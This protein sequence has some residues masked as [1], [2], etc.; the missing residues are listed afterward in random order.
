MNDEKPNMMSN[1]SYF[2]IPGAIS[3]FLLA[4]SPGE[5]TRYA[6]ILLIIPVLSTIVIYFIATNYDRTKENGENIAKAGQFFYFSLLIHS[7]G[8]VIIHFLYIYSTNNLN[9]QESTLEFAHIFKWIPFIFT[10]ISIGRVIKLTMNL[11]DRDS[12]N[13][14]KTNQFVYAH[15]FGAVLTFFSIFLFIAYYL[16][17]AIGFDDSFGY[18]KNRGVIS[19]CSFSQ[20]AKTDKQENPFSLSI[21]TSV[22]ASSSDIN[23]EDK[24][25]IFAILFGV[26]NTTLRKIDIDKEIS[27]SCEVWVGQKW[28]ENVISTIGDEYN[29]TQLCNFLVFFENLK[30]NPEL[31]FQIKLLSIPTGGNGQENEKIGKDR[32]TD[33][34]EKIRKI[35]KSLGIKDDDIIIETKEKQQPDYADESELPDKAKLP[36]VLI[37]VSISKKPFLIA[38]E[39]FREKLK[40]DITKE[41]TNFI[42]IS[43][44]LNKNLENCANQSVSDKCNSK[45]NVPNISSCECPNVKND[46]NKLNDFLG[47]NENKERQNLEGLLNKIVTQKLSPIEKSI[48]ILSSCNGNQIRPLLHY[49]YF[50]IYTITTT[51]YGDLMPS[52]PFS[53]FIVSIAN[54]IEVFFIVVFFNV[55][56]SAFNNKKDTKYSL[57]SKKSLPDSSKTAED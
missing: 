47:G 15:A 13:T 48:N 57:S 37:K 7:I 17:Y 9:N 8:L 41:T 36:V 16:S 51:G 24:D 25:K 45:I 32:N 54:L 18:G 52:S 6:S 27:E 3:V 39:D 20:Q 29:L 19:S 46:I 11:L 34:E 4:Y 1:L 50:T 40:V 12:E 56:L 21:I 14:N 43:K 5:S 2:I 23:D 31:A 33:V 28:K 22:Y 26:G 49:I 38:L 55:L 35:L 53:Q 10:V 44:E 30:Q 42:E